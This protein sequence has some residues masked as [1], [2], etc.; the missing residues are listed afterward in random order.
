M[1]VRGRICNPN[2]IYHEKVFRDFSTD[3]DRAIWQS[4]D[5]EPS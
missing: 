4:L 5:Q 3:P 1:V 2:K